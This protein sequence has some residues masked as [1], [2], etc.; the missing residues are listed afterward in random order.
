NHGYSNRCHR[1]SGVRAEREWRHQRDRGGQ[2]QLRPSGGEHLFHHACRRHKHQ[3]RYGELLCSEADTVGVA[4]NDDEYVKYKSRRMAAGSEP[5]AAKDP[6]PKV[7][8]HC[9]HVFETALMSSDALL[10]TNPA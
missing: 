3:L 7:G 8:F 6:Y 4:V 2:R 9:E 1:F 10:V 5:P